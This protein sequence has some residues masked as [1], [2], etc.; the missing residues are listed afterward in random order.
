VCGLTIGKWLW[1]WYDGRFGGELG[2]D[3]AEY[4]VGADWTRARRLESASWLRAQHQPH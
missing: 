4:S 3:D 2:G 1:L